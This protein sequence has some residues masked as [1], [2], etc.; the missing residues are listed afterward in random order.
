MTVDELRAALTA[1]REA[2]LEAL[3]TVTEREFAAE[4]APGETL[5]GLLATLAP[6][7]RE[8]VRSARAASGLPPRAVAQAAAAPARP[9]PPQVIHDLAGARYETELLLAALSAHDVAPEVEAA[10]TSV[11][12]REHAAATRIEAR[13]RLAPPP[14]TGA[15][16]PEE[17]PGLGGP[18]MLP[19]MLPR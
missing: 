13:A 10:L 15:A 11:A 6:A 19:P 7:E 5:V 2:L 8:A 4:L 3:R 18:P 12:E 14:T 9:A 17:R 1:S 16:R